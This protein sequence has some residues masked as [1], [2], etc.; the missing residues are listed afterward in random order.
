[1]A[2]QTFPDQSELRF[3]GQII[4]AAGITIHGGAVKGRQADGC[5]QVFGDD[6][7]AERCNW[8]GLRLC[9]ARYLLEYPLQ[10]FREIYGL[11]NIP[12]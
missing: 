3:G 9:N 7:A 1:M 5:W 10:R 6:P 2:G 4:A 11:D 8:N 12:R